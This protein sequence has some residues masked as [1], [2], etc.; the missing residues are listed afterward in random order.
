MI[1][2]YDGQL[3]D[4]MPGNITGKPEV[5]ALSHALQQACRLIFQYSRRLYIYSSLDEQPEEVIDLLASELR[6]QYYR[7]T[8]DLPTKRRLVKNTLIWYMTAGTPEAVEELVAAVFGEGE[9]KEW[10]E[11]GDDPYYFKI[12]TN[13]MLTPEMNDFFS[14]MIRRV[15]NTRSHL[16]A[17][18][19]H[20]TANHELLSGAAASPNYKPSA[21]IDGYAVGREAR[22]DVHAGALASQQSRPAPIWDGFQTE[23]EEVTAGT[24]AGAAGAAGA[25]RT[26]QA[27]IVD[28]FSFEGSKVIGQ[29]FAGGEMAAT[30]K[31]AAIREG[32]EGSAAP[33]EG[34]AYAGAAAGQQSSQ[35]PPAIR[36]GLAFHGAAVTGA[37]LAATASNSKYK[38]SVKEGGKKNATTI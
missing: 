17:I 33:V 20:R 29:A 16:R 22:Q 4:I 35:R 18:D 12:V 23:G 25:S 3:T 10:D 34:R 14:I 36:E 32:L 27:A 7:S 13:A 28:G 19:I 8:L 2:Y 9:V 15:K 30:E 31:Q 11:Y 21:V 6:T 26:R 38:N 1:S 24:F 37:I 5:K